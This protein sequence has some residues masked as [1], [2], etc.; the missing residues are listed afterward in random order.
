M[1]TLTS[2]SAYHY[3][4]LLPAL[5]QSY[6]D[7]AAIKAQ[8]SRVAKVCPCAIASKMLTGGFSYKRS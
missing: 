3:Y 1:L 5:V 8:V 2:L 6:W 4:A 7:E